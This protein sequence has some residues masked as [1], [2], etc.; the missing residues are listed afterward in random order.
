MPSNHAWGKTQSKCKMD[1]GILMQQNE[2]FT[3]RV[4]DSLFQL[5]FK[6][7]LLT[8]FWYSVTE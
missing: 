1:Q 7:L 8:E 4:S 2:K 6:E 5:T 3:D